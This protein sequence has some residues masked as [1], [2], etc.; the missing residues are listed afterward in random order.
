M[1]V[2]DKCIDTAAQDDEM[3]C[4]YYKQVQKIAMVYFLCTWQMLYSA[5]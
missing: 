2:S 4:S 5:A 1:P 3:M